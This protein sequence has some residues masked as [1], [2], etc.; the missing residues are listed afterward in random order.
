[1]RSEREYARASAKLGQRDGSR[2][3]FRECRF[4]NRRARR[5]ARRAEKQQL[6]K[7]ILDMLRE[8]EEW[9]TTHNSQVNSQS[10]QS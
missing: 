5:L 8:E 2:N 1:M 3:L 6:L 9:V 10:R 4:N 7:E